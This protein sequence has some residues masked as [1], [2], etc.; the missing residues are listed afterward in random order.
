LKISHVLAKK[1]EGGYDKF[2]VGFAR[3]LVNSCQTCVH[4]SKVLPGIC[5]A[6]LNGIPED[7]LSGKVDHKTPVDGDGGITYEKE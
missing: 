7:I 6:F 3:P 1:K 4:R 5:A 2:S